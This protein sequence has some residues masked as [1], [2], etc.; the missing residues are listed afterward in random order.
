MKRKKSGLIILFSLLL[1]S[2]LFSCKKESSQDPLIGKWKAVTISVNGTSTP[3]PGDLFLEIK[4]DSTLSMGGTTANWKKE[5]NLLKVTPET[6]KEDSSI[7]EKL[8]DQELILT[9]EEQGIKTQM[10][11]QKVK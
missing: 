9:T 5:G 3:A 7:I 6:M 1:I 4:T 10:F 8:T 11:F 2:A